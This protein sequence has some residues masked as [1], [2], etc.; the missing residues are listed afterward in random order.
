MS[1][2]IFIPTTVFIIRTWQQS[3]QNL[4]RVVIIML[5]IAY[6]IWA[7]LEYS[8]VP[9]TIVWVIPKPGAGR[10]VSGHV[11][12]GGEVCTIAHSQIHDSLEL[13]LPPQHFY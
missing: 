2:Y 3:L 5:C 1:S 9:M 7:H 10:Q 11:T 13:Q 8:V 4:Q 6:C 12:G